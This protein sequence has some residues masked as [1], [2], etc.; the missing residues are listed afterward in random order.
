MENLLDKRLHL[1]SIHFKHAGNPQTSITFQGEKTHPI[2][3]VTQE[4]VSQG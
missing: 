2:P 4:Y 1:F 3:E